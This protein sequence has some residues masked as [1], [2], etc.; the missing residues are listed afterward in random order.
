MLIFPLDGLLDE[1]AC[2]DFLVQSLHP[3]GLHCPH[4]HPLPQ[5]QPAHD[6]HRN[7]VRDYRCAACGAVYN[8][9]TGTGLKGSRWPCSTL[10]LM[11]KGFAQ[12]TPTKH[13][14][15]ELNVSRPQWLK[16]RHP[17]H[18]LLEA[19]FP[20][21]GAAG[22]RHR[23]GRDVPERRREGPPAHRPR[24]STASASQQA[25]RTWPL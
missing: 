3:E 15:Q 20:P 11:L 5:E 16:R 22:P 1:Q 6:R 17:V 13:L 14:A 4:G 7:P 12:G 24:R 2:Y 10:V 19:R 21:L 8:L 25:A 18:A 23:S 9:F